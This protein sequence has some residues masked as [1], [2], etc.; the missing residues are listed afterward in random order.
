[1]NLRTKIQLSFAC[2]IIAIMAIVGYTSF[3]LNTQA[4]NTIIDD[5]IATS[6]NLASSHIS[7]QLEDYVS[8]VTLA[9]QSEILQGKASVEEKTAYLQTYID[10]YGF[11]SANILDKDGISLKDN[12]DFSDRD[13]V[14]KALAGTP[15]ISEVTL[16]KYTNTYGISVAAPICSGNAINGVVYFR[17]DIDFMTDILKGVHIS[18]NSYAYLIDQDG[19]IIVHPS[20]DLIL[21]YNLLEQSG[22]MKTL[23]EQMTAGEAGNGQYT[24]DQ[25]VILCG[26]SPVENTNGWSLVIAA[27]NS[28]YTESSDRVTKISLFISA[29]G[30]FFAILISAVIAKSICKPIQSVKNAMMSISQGNLTANIK[31]ATG[32]DEL[33]VLQNTTISLVNTLGSIIGDTNYILDRMASC[34]L[35][36]D[37]MKNYPGEFNKLSHSVN[38]IRHTLT[39]LIVEIQ[40]SVYNVENGSHELAQAT[41]LMSQGAVTQASS[42]QTLAD[43]LTDIVKRIQN[44]SENEDLINSKLSTLDGQIQTAN[45]QMQELKEAVESV[46][47]MSSDIQ[48]IVSTID[49]IAFQTNILSLNASVE[50]A[51]AGEMGKGFAVVAEEVRNLAVKSGDASKKTS[52]LINECIASIENA[53]ICA[54]A[55]FESLSG[56][57]TDSAEIASA[58]QSISEDTTEQAAKSTRIQQEVNNISDVVQTNTSTAEETASATSALSEQAENLKEM[59]RHFQVK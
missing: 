23:G 12:T 51:R 7:R 3:N 34:D 5:G 55:T 2:T 9:G 43:D 38:S 24:F 28:D 32:K 10:T 35:T 44:N 27:P 49:S 15:N 17:M 29:L 13:Y 6:A 40:N 14:Q 11:T 47:T 22:N 16:S 8:A 4:C 20:E 21:N 30:I 54:D 31:P 41:S 50:A 1:M 42:I 53:K 36:T 25:Q 57:V 48:K 39:Q 19:N 37:D 46:E 33:A 52:D 56:I 45:G 58:F 59:I 26:F 18:N